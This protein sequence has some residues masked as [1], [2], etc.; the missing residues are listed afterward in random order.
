[1]V[2]LPPTTLAQRIRAA[3]HLAGLTQSQ[4]ALRAGLARSHV[5]LILQRLERGG[6]EG[7]VK[8]ATLRAIAAAAGVSLGWLASGEGSPHPGGGPT[9][10]L[11]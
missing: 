9:F 3:Q 2:P 6:D 1:M 5:S 10:P 8:L 11:D 7:T 4:L